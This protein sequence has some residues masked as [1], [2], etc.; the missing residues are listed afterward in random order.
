MLNVVIR[1]LAILCMIPIVLFSI[2]LSIFWNLFLMV[3]YIF[4][5]LK[6]KWKAGIK[7][8]KKTDA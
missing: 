6:R 8:A 7:E 4:V 5:R 1:I 3:D 2:G